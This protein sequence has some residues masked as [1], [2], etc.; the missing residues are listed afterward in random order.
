MYDVSVI[1]YM[2]VISKL[3]LTIVSRNS[4]IL[5]GHILCIIYS[6]IEHT[7]CLFFKFFSSFIA[8]EC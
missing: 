5:D 6:T 2:R 1:M 7:V 8:S 3:D 4:F